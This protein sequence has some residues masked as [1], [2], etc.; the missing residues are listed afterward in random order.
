MAELL[1]C[2][3]L[4]CVLH[5][6][7]MKPM[8]KERGKTMRKAAAAG[9]ILA[10]IILVAGGLD[11]KG[12][13]DNFV[14]DVQA[15]DETTQKEEENRS[16]EETEL[17]TQIDTSAPVTAGSRI[18]VVSKSVDG[19]FWKAIRTGM[20]DAVKDV[21]AA[22]GYTSDDQITMTFEGASNEQ[23][24]EKQINTLDAVIAENP[25]VLCLSAG[26][27]D[28]CQ[29]Q[30]EAAKEN[31]I[32]VVAFDS[33]VTDSDMIAAFRGTDNTSVGKL[34]GEKLADAIGKSGKVAIFSA[35]EKTESSRRR[36]E[37]FNEA[38]SAYSDI[39][40]VQELYMDKVEDMQSAIESTLQS[41]PDLAGVFCT[42]ADVS[43]LYLDTEKTGDHVLTMVGVD[44]TSKQQEAIRNGVE[45]GVVSQD[46]YRI[47][48]QT[49]LAA[50]QLTVPKEEVSGVERTVL[51]DPA[52]I[53]SSSLDDPE[54]SD[55]LYGK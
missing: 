49:I 4:L 22:Y 26:D 11:R 39:S 1:V 29:A 28:S 43:D 23:D 44:A 12:G 24:V 45:A 32:S 41:Y 48:Y 51:Y 2:L 9:I 14:A 16:S 34:A 54:Y 25:T 36:V 27:E 55:Y 21:N 53:D 7:Q 46:P 31:G 52:W 42:N 35:Q 20:E 13:S 17:E 40:V 8:T 38:I 5:Q 37:G 3:Q 50:V 30:I 15:N 6:A 33:N 47:G 18:A 19:E 10:G